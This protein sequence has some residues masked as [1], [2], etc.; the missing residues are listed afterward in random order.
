VGIKKRK[1]KKMRI[2]K[3]GS[4]RRRIERRAIRCT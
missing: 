1:R 2:M 4:R 3:R